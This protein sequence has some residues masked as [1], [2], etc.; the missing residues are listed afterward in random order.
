VP[1]GGSV[2]GL[3]AWAFVARALDLRKRHEAQALREQLHREEH[4][5]RQAAEIAKAEIEAGKLEIQ[6]EPISVPR[7][8]ED[9]QRLFSL[10]AGEKGLHLTIDL[11]PQMPRGLLLDEVRLRQVLFNVIGNALKF[12][13][14][15]QV[16]IRAWVEAGAR[17]SSPAAA[18]HDR[19]SDGSS[20]ASGAFGRAAGGDARAPAAWPGSDADAAEP[21]ETRVTLMIDVADTGIGIPADQQAH[22]FGAFTQASGQST[23]KFGGTGLGLAI[24]RRLTEMM[25]GTITLGS[26]PGKGSTFQF[27]FPDVPITEPVDIRSAGAIAE[28]GF[29]QFARSTILVADDVAL[30]RQLLAGYFE[31]TGH[32]LLTASNGLGALEQAERH[33]PDVILMDMRMPELNGCET[34]ARLKANAALRHIPVIA[35]TASSFREEEARAR[36]ICDGFIRKPFNRSELIAELQRFLKPA[37]TAP[38]PAPIRTAATAATAAAG[39]LPPQVVRE[40]PRL[41]EALRQEQASVWPRLRQT[42]DMTQI[43]EFARRL[44]D[45]AERG[46]FPELEAYAARLLREVDALDTDQLTISLERFGDVCEAVANHRTAAPAS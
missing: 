40:R 35:V 12:T 37:P 43:E 32:T 8:I 38:E 26:A 36:R 23:R 20:E 24:T 18:T 30:N 42:M 10:K 45:C 22:I 34:T 1:A 14:K 4:E 19:A 28:D 33:R 17:A 5:A 7:L 41:I 13:E 46:R 39:P 11:D 44:V 27:R 6:T 3:L 31:G 15:G 29:T 9:M 25:R 21:D 2:L 16:K